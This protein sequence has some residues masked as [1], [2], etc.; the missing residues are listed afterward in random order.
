MAYSTSAKGSSSIPGTPG[1]YLR[2]IG[3]VGTETV[4]VYPTRLPSNRGNA[5]INPLALTGKELAEGKIIAS[6]DC[7]NSGERPPGG[8]PAAPACRIQKGYQG[9]KR[10]PSVPAREYGTP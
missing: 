7:N 4:S 1:H 6:Y 10:F 2:Q 5:Y 3:P 8:V 9:G